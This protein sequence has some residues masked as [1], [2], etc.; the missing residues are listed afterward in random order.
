[1]RRIFF[2]ALLIFIPT[3]LEPYLTTSI[4]VPLHPKHIV[5]VKRLL[6][7]YEKQTVLP[8]EVVISMSEYQEHLH[9]N[10]IEE[11]ISIKRPFNV[12]IAT[13]PEKKQ[14]GENR[15]I[16][17]SKANGD[18]LIVN[19]ADDMP[20]PQR[21]EIIRYL[22]ELYN[23]DHLMHKY[24]LFEDPGT[25]KNPNYEV[26]DLNKIPFELESINFKALSAFMLF[27]QLKNI[28]NGNIA[29][30][31]KVFKKIRWSNK[32]I[33]EDQEFN[34]M[35]YQNFKNRIIVN[36]PLIDYISYYSTSLKVTYE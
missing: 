2:K 21:V 7:N 5:N 31:R 16:A 9:K 3:I 32:A 27:A 24:R 13:T 22:F 34:F 1:M 8:T 6:T 20:H 33:A 28:H 19:D 36:L 15:N 10:N 11:I 12:I 35:A 29:I 18:I 23:I 14:P 25:Y 26:Y 4:I 17:C 30:S